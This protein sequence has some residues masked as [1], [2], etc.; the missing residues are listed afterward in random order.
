LKIDNQNLL[1][2][3]TKGNNFLL[4][5]AAGCLLVNKQNITVSLNYAH[6]RDK[7]KQSNNSFSKFAAQMISNLYWGRQ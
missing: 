2:S 4:I 6:Y 5:G 3:V 7:V 1:H